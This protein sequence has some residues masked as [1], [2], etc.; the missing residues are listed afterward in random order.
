MPDE[1]K[2][3]AFLRIFGRRQRKT[4]LPNFEHPETTQLIEAS[5]RLAPEQIIRTVE[6]RNDHFLEH[7]ATGLPVID[8]PALLQDVRKKFHSDRDYEAVLKKCQ[9]VYTAAAD[10]KAETLKPLVDDALL[11]LRKYVIGLTKRN[12]KDPT[13][14]RNTKLNVCSE[15]EQH[16]NKILSVI[17][18]KLETAIELET[19]SATINVDHVI[20]HGW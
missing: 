1:K 6:L 15:Q 9:S 7:F 3:S 4:P 20:D 14:E 2:K 5:R 13:P 17:E 8:V 18:L 16:L 12:E 11:T 19:L 10:P